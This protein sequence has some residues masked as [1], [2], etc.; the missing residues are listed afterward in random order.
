MQGNIVISDEGRSTIV[1]MD[2]DGDISLINHDHPNYVRIA[3]A[4]ERGEDPSE[5]LTAGSTDW[6]QA[7][8]LDSVDE[9]EVE[10]CVD[11]G[12]PLDAMFFA[13]ACSDEDDYEPEAFDPAPVIESL[14]QTIERYRTEERDPTGLL[15]FM[16]RL[17]RNPSKRSRDQ[18]F[19]WSV[20]KDLTINVDGYIIGFKGVREDLTSVKAGPALV[21]GVPFDG[22]IPNDI[23]NVISMTRSEVQDDPT[24]PCS[25][26][27]HVG[28]FAYARGWGEKVVE[29]EIDPSDIVSVPT[30]SGFAKLRC[31]SYKV[32]GVHDNSADLSAYE[33][34][35][36]FDEQEAFDSFAAAAE[37]PKGFFKALIARRRNR[38]VADA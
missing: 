37:A 3:A 8:Y 22:H 4:V 27:L 15:R 24:I 16:D 11:C 34:E 35:A 25:T 10:Y 12:E 6:F 14:S 30:D 7:L 19:Q 18:L 5:W 28:S 2:D 31:C 13:C 38:K 36:Q 17:A 21:N 33:A 32:V 1:L 29:V 23:G 9:D 26:G 20:A